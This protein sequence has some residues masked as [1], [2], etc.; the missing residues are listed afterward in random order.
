MDDYASV[1]KLCAEA[2]PWMALM[3]ME[4]CASNPSN[5]H[6]RVMLDDLLAYRRRNQGFV[7]DLPF[8]AYSAK[9]FAAKPLNRINEL[10]TSMCAMSDDDVGW[11]PE[12]IGPVAKFLSHYLLYATPPITS[13]ML[14]SL[15]LRFAN[16]GILVPEDLLRELAA[17]CHA[18]SAAAAVCRCLFLVFSSP[19]VR[20]T[21]RTC[22]LLTRTAS[23]HARRAR[24]A[25]LG[26]AR[27]RGDPGSGAGT[28][29]GTTCRCRPRRCPCY[30]QVHSPGAARPGG[31]RCRRVDGPRSCGGPAP[32]RGA[33]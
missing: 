33:R 29:A 25:R 1:D 9:V 12:T 10:S 18:A 3:L 15:T 30:T 14:L 23:Q 4:S 28:G 13:E 27:T 26:R 20:L 5:P 19:G 32:R 31:Y 7:P 2:G 24:R 6:N 11:L 21:L 22:C 16:W 8:P 17:R